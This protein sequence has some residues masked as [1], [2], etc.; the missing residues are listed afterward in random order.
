MN[1]S[2]NKLLR[3]QLK[4]YAQGELLEAEHPQFLNFVV[5]AYVQYQQEVDLLERSLFITSNELNERNSMLKTQLNELSET[6][7]KLQQF[8]SVLNATFDATGEM[9]FVYDIQGVIVATNTMA[10]TFLHEHGLSATEHWSQL[11][12]LLR[13]PQQ[14]KE[15]ANTLKVDNLKHLSSTL[16]FCNGKFYEYRSLPQL[17]G[18]ELIGRVWCFKDVTQE[19]KSVE[20][21]QHQAYHDALTGLPNRSLLLDR[22]EHAETIAKRN[23][24]QLG[25]LF[26]DLDNF[27]R[28]NDTEGHDGGD[29]LL[30]EVVHRIKSR[31][32]E[33]D[34][35]SR[36]GGDEFVILYESMQ[37]PKAAHALCHSILE[38]LAPPFIING[39]QHYISPSI[40]VAMYPQDDDQAEGLIRKADMAMYQA[41]DKGKNTYQFYDAELESSAL[42]QLQIERELRDA[43]K[44]NQLFPYFQPKIN[45]KSSEIAG[46]ELLMRWVKEDGSYISPEVFI[47]IAESTGLISQIGTIAIS[48]AYKQ[49]EKWR[50]EGIQH[51]HLAINFSILEFQDS[52]QIALLLD[53]ADTSNL[54]GENIIIELTE[55]IF[56]QDKDKISKT[57]ELLKTRGFSFAL[58]DFGK[59]YSSFSYLQSLPIRYLKIDKSFLQNVTTNKQSAAIAR[60]IIDIG[61]NLELETIAEGIEDQATLDYVREINCDLAQGFHLYRPMDSQT[62]NQLVIDKGMTT[63][64]N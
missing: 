30:I 49:L 23:D 62:F 32:R 5:D 47:P 20:I 10:K 1:T 15:I 13:Y 17:K 33:Q 6:K 42:A 3:R 54:G 24:S 18:D 19:K 48:A 50:K 46:A 41:K 60:S 43:I 25:V 40:G 2:Q 31:L 8:V 53:K 27:K 56:M 52:E 9:I 16:E 51:L 36:L 34:T 14:I 55:S 12:N 37:D 4:R 64:A 61:H 22:I 7:N 11:L 29:Q 39:R 44:S 21:I 58:D 59:G 38:L 26:I 35:L 57:M 28:V 63:L 45:L